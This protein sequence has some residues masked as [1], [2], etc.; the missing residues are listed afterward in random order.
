MTRRFLI[1][2]I[3]GCVAVGLAGCI[4][5]GPEARFSA[6]PRTGWAPL[7]VH[8]NAGRSESSPNGLIVD[9]AWDLDG[10]PASGA[11][12]DYTF[13]V[14]GP[15]PVRLTVTDST[16]QMASTADTIT[17][18]SLPPVAS[19]RCLTVPLK[20][21]QDCA[22]DASASDDPDGVIV[23]YVWSFGD[24]GAD[25]GDVVTHVFAARGEYTVTLTV[26]DDTG[27]QASVSQTFT[28]GSSC[29]G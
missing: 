10:E 18:K 26:I 24:G 22:F 8:F 28:V 14:K 3:C 7:T 23:S 16:G 17:V 27:D 5:A 29:C 11:E 12:V 1:A 4:A 13:T 9:Y 25:E 6:T 19:F 2:V 21:E 15:H 20:A